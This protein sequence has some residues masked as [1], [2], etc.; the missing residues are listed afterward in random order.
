MRSVLYDRLAFYVGPIPTTR[1]SPPFGRGSFLAKASSSALTV[2]S[3]AGSVRYVSIF[4][5]SGD[6]APPGPTHDVGR[7][8][9]KGIRG[10]EIVEEE[11]AWRTP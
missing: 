11:I 1:P 10:E 2:P 7:P 5:H 9:G 3:N 4:Q 8:E 6:A